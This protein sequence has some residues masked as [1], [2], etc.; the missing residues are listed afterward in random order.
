MAHQ[1]V[2]HVSAPALVNKLS[3]LWALVENCANYS[4]FI[5]FPSDPSTS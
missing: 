4:A 2:C 1:V 5:D 3:E